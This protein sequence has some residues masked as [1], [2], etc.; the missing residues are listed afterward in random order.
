MTN[1]VPL[2]FRRGSIVCHGADPNHMLVVRSYPD[3]TACILVESERAGN[4]RLRDFPTRELV[5][6][7][8]SAMPQAPEADHD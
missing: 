3:K 4:L 8:P 6:E 2:T 1:V 7:L 5:L